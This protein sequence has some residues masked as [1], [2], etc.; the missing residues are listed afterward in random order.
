MI[1]HSEIFLD[2]SFI[3]LTLSMASPGINTSLSCSLTPGINTFLW[4]QRGKE[5]RDGGGRWRGR[6]EVKEC[7]GMATGWA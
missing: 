6:G 2:E 7:G 1:E 5:R 4:G 3:L